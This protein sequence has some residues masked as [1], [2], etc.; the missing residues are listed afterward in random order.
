M[1]PCIWR[2]ELGLGRR[3]GAI[4]CCS[5]ACHSLLAHDEFIV[6]VWL[7]QRMRIRGWKRISH[8]TFNCF[9]YHLYFFN[10]TFNSLNIFT[11]YIIVFIIKW[12]RVKMCYSLLRLC[13]FAQF[14]LLQKDHFLSPAIFLWVRWKV[15]PVQPCI[16][17]SSECVASSFYVYWIHTTTSAVSRHV[18]LGLSF[19]PG[20]WEH[21]P[22]WCDSSNFL[23]RLLGVYHIVAKKEENM[24][25]LSCPT[26][27]CCSVLHSRWPD[28]QS[29]GPF[30]TLWVF[31]GHRTLA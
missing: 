12:R 27:T 28:T 5:L 23:Q 7:N 22:G 4:A 11:M 15:A 30:L 9:L 6:S 26:A 1:N 19:L 20:G 14:P 29:H 13:L 8:T 16:L 2:V 3:H 17:L 25:V 10:T 24:A 21:Y 18:L 31:S